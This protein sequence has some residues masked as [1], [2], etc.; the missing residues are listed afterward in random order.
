MKFGEKLF[1]QNYCQ[2]CLTRFAV[3]LPLPSSI[4]HEIRL[5]SRRS[6]GK[7]AKNCTK[8]CDTRAKL[9]FCFLN[10]LLLWRS[11][12]RHC[13]LILRY[14]LFLSVIWCY[15]TPSSKKE[16]MHSLLSYGVSTVKDGIV[17]PSFHNR[18]L[19][20]RRRRRQRKHIKNNLISKTTIFH[21]HHAF[22]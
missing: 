6:R 13:R 21:V 17:F 12:C 5:F 20:I 10:L 14:P 16:R 2:A 15:H 3:F 11:R 22:L 19:N 4:K 7:T 18:D 8:R 1:K 9:L